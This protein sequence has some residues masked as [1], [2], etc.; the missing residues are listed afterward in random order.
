MP[1]RVGRPIEPGEFLWAC[2]RCLYL[3]ML[4]ILFSFLVWSD[5]NSYLSKAFLGTYHSWKHRMWV[6]KE[7]G[8]QG[9]LHKM[10][11]YPVS[12]A[13]NSSPWSCLPQSSVFWIPFST[14]NHPTALILVCLV[15]FLGFFFILFCLFGLDSLFWFWGF[16]LS[17]GGWNICCFCVWGTGYICEDK[18][19]SDTIYFYL[20]MVLPLALK[21][22]LRP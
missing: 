11:R 7:E 19:I 10:A 15:V 12:R 17:G 8:W 14:S 20:V 18:S 9:W 22:W 4:I 6:V 13:W 5:C 16:F 21:Q 3:P 1:F 2:H